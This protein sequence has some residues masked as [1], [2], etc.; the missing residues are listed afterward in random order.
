MFK[1]KPGI[2]EHPPCYKVRLIVRGYEQKYDVDFDEFFAPMI[3]WSIIKTLIAITTS[4]RHSIYHLDVKI[5]FFNG[6]SID[7]IDMK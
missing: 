2:N 6:H 4:K 1:L 5:A 3:K 7:K